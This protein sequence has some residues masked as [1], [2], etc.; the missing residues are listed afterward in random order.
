VQ[1]QPKE[2][3]QYIVQVDYNDTE[4]HAGTCFYGPFD[5]ADANDF[6]QNWDED[7]Q[8]LEDAVVIFLNK[9]IL[10]DIE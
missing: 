5:E 2:L 10:E 3:Q 9:A 8:E 7:D 6:V 1:E 4:G